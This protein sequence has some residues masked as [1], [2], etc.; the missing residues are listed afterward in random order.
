MKE[1]GDLD[2]IENVRGQGDEDV[3]RQ[4]GEGVNLFIRLDGGV[5]GQYT[6]YP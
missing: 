2:E 5:S 3:K 6:S 1:G 4:R